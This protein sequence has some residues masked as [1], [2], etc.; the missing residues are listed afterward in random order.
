MKNQT[1]LVVALLLTTAVFS[2][3]SQYYSDPQEKFKEAKEYFQKEQYSLAYPLLKELQQSVRETDKANYP[4]TVQE[5][6]YYTTACALKQNESR[7]EEKAIDYIKLEKNTPRVQMMSFHLGEYYFRKKDFAKAAEQFEQTNIANLSNKEIAEMKF[8]QGYSY[9]TLQKFAQ[10]KP[11]FNTIRTMKDDPNYLD[12]NYYYGF[13]SFRDRE[14]GPALESFKIVENEKDYATV[15]PYYIAQ[16]YYIQGK[17]EEALSECRRAVEL[18][19]VEKDA[20]NGPLMIQWS[21]ISAGWVGEKD[22]AIEQ[23]S[24]A[25]RVPGPLTYGNLK[26]QPFWDPLRGDPRFEQIVNSLAPKGAEVTH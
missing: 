10:A 14:Y 20:F 13:L 1:L 26:L 22:L 9:F 2:Q 5:I 23:L 18:L 17:K 12:A 19:P 15:V 16:I 6:N 24:M 11:L 4:V 8:Q 25:V 21:A 3:Q 7:A